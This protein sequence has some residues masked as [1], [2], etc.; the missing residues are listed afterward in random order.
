M[1]L[2]GYTGYQALQAR[3]ALQAVASDFTQLSSELTAGDQA[4]AAKTLKQAQVHAGVALRNTNGPG[5]ALT[6]HLAGVG[7]D[8][9]AVRTVA[10]VTDVLAVQVLPKVVEASARLKPENLRPHDGRVN[11]RPIVAVA[12]QVVAA[13]AEL[14][15]Q[16]ARVQAIDASGLTSQLAEPVRQMQR[17]L[18]EAADLSRQASLAVRLLPPMLGENG[19]R[20]YLVLFQNNAEVRTTGGIPGAFATIVAD[21]GKIRLGTQG[22]AGTIGQLSRPVLPLTA[23]EVALFQKKMGIFPQDVNFTPDFPRSAELVSAMWRRARGGSLDGVVSTDPVAL[24]YLLRGTGPVPLPD[25]QRLTADDAVRLL[26]NEVYFKISDPHAQNVF[27]AATAKTVFNDLAAGRGSPHAILDA[28]SQAANERRI[29]VWSA[30]P[31]EERLLAPTRLGGGVPTVAN[32]TPRVDLYLNDGTQGK[33]DY[34]LDY[35]T[36]VVGRGCQAGRQRLRVTLT[37]RSTAPRDAARV[38]PAYVLGDAAARPGDIQTV[39]YLYLPVDGYLKTAT[40]QGGTLPFS[41]YTHM[42]RTVEVF[43]VGLRPGEQQRFT[44]D[45]VSGPG[46]TGTP[47]VRVTP[48]AHGTGVGTVRGGCS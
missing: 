19:R 24:S 26:L 30:H 35:S 5:W 4:A 22:D 40:F 1:L 8:V 16:N 21:H 20:T 25:G 14:Q 37:M 39:V 18:G 31:A 28:L 9:Q 33:M 42:G 15:V 6:T 27:F 11:L 43:G 41:T 34:Y 38:L 32:A 48:G 13:D 45:L 2:V 44:F 47:K 17:K 36:S 3:D 12:P 7:S 29:L 46:Q 10:Q 23:E